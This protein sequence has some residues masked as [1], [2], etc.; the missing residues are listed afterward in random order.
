MPNLVNKLVADEY[1]RLLGST[2]GLLIVSASGLSVQET[3]ALRIRLSEGGARLRMVRN[4][5]ARRALAE[6]GHEFPADTFV[7]NVCVAYGS[8]E[9]SVHA[10]KVL[11][12]PEVRKA[13][14]ITLRGALFDG[15]QLSAADAEELAG[16]PDKQTLRA[17]LLGVLQGP[18]RGLVTLLDALPAG[19]ARVLQAHVDAAAGGG[20]ATSQE[21]P[22]EVAAEAS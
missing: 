4:S 8:T 22:G 3:E 13:G 19:L 20:G 21:E 14:K 17:Q 1:G 5:L 6:L 18:A 12:A 2:E 11:T 7:G 16:V 9:A 15:S 10:A